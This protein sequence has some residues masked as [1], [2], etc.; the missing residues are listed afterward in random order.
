M[1]RSQW[2]CLVAALAVVL[3]LFCGPST[4]VAAT[5]PASASAGPEASA[6][7]PAGPAGPE[8]SAAVPD[9]VPVVAETGDDGHGVPG[10]GRNGKRNGTEPAVPGRARTAHDQAPGLAEGG[11]PAAIGPE[12]VRPP[13]PISP[14]GPE[15]AAPGPV[16]L[17]VLRV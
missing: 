1:S 4:A 15:A 7:G 14:R 16:E 8:A 6:A 2:C 12:P 3:G 17:S 9:R 10:C 11:L 13:A 5:A